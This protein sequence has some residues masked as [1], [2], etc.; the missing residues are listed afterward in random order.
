MTPTL[1]SPAPDPPSTFIV[2]ADGEEALEGWLHVQP[3]PVPPPQIDPFLPHLSAL[4][5]SAEVLRYTT[6]CTEHWLS[7]QGVLRE[8]FRRNL[9]LALAVVIPLLIIAPVITLLLDKLQGW[10]ASAVQIATN[11]AQMPALTTTMLLSAAG[12]LFIRWLLR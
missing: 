5:R 3:Q 7:P 8:W 12:V 10:S 6:Q 4:E 1:P 2:A 11:L 9:R